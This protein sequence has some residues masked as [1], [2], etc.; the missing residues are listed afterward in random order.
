[1][2]KDRVV[3]SAKQIKGTVKQVVGKA[4]GDTKLEIRK[5]RLTKL[6]VGFR[7]PSAV[8]RTRSRENRSGASLLRLRELRA[9]RGIAVRPWWAPLQSDYRRDQVHS[10]FPPRKSNHVARTYTDHYPRHLSAWWL[11]RPLRRLRLWLWSRWHWCHRCRRDHPRRLAAYGSALICQH[12][13]P[14]AMLNEIDL[15]DDV[16]KI[17]SIDRQQASLVALVKA[18]RA[19]FAFRKAIK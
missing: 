3:G 18:L 1:M 11:Q 19:G 8:S 9:G 5:A 15:G 14:L 7:T 6:K 10:Y 2:D 13:L 17:T 12:M 4:V 16:P